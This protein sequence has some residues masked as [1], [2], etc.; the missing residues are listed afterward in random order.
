LA[1]R[2]IAAPILS[3]EIHFPNDLK[4]EAVSSSLISAIPGNL[5]A[6]S[7]IFL[8]FLKAPPGW[9]LKC[10]YVLNKDNLFRSMDHKSPQLEILAE[11]DNLHVVI[12]AG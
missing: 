4:V 7:V 10:Y 1:Q 9:A 12:A 3:K 6:I 8:H 5:S 2:E 11:S